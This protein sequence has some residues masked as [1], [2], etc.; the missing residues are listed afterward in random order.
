MSWLI[1]KTK[2]KRCNDFGAYGQIFITKWNKKLVAVKRIDITENDSTEKELYALKKLNA[3]NFKGIARTLCYQIADKYA[4]FVMETWKDALNLN[5]HLRINGNLSL[6]D[7]H[8]YFKQLLSTVQYC[9]RRNIVHRD[10][11]DRN[12]LILSR[13]KQAK[14]IDF[15]TC[16]R[17]RRKYTDHYTIKDYLPPEYIKNQ[18]Y[19]GDGQTVWSLGVILYKMIMNK[20]PPFTKKRRF[21]KSIRKCKLMTMECKKFLQGCLCKN[22]DKRLKLMDLN[23][24]P[25]IRKPVRMQL[26]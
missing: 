16:A 20:L 24:H 2:K 13:S 17:I 26:L 25:F 15:G 1:P 23:H 18:W 10:I 21:Y 6:R 8:M 22:P 5:K 14:L 3:T 9:Y 11:H 7:A 19:T 12:I 4:Y